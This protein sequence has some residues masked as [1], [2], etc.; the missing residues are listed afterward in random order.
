MKLQLLI[1]L[2]CIADATPGFANG[3]VD[4]TVTGGTPCYNGAAGSVGA[5]AEYQIGV[6]FAVCKFSFNF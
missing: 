4:L 6:N 1:F 5:G 3:G 2:E